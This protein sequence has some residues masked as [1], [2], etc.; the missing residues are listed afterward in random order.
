ME[1]KQDVVFLSSN[2]E[3]LEKELE[4]NI[5]KQLGDIDFSQLDSLLGNLDNNS[6]DHIKFSSFIEIVKSFINA[7]N[8]SLFSNFF[9]YSLSILFQNVLSYLPYFAIIVALAIIYSLIGNL[10]SENSKS[11]SSLI[12]VV[13]FC[14]IA[15]TILKIIFSLMNEVSITITFIEKQM[16]VIFP[17]LL[18]LITSIGSVVTAT[19]F[20]PILAVLSVA[21][22]KLFTTVL[23][24]I[25]IFSVVF[26]VVGNISNNV[27]MDKFSK[28]FSSTF[29]YIVGIVFT[30]FIAFLTIQGLTT[31]S[32]DAISLRTAKFA[33]KSYVPILGS[34][35]S[36]GVGLILASSVLIKNAVGATGL[37]VLGLSI[38]MPIIKVGIV[39]LLLKLISAIIE[40]LCDQKISN[41]LFGLSKSLNMLNISLLAVGFMYLISLSMLMC[42]S[43]IF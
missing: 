42:C 20:Q 15:L 33:I 29:N 41:F 34:Y 14:S 35:L 4:D 7:E 8:S 25:F 23:I 27:R 32:I 5:N 40:T 17:I 1:S 37:V 28:F 12:H 11:V 6:K 30:I 13:C 26:N 2:E 19:S 10:S 3:S 22:T 24:P 16:E 31:S 36:D 21:I 43:N 18:T 9:S 39:I 38:L